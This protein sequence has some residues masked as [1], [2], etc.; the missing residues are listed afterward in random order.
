MRNLIPENKKIMLELP[1]YIGVRLTKGIA[2][3]TGGRRTRNMIRT[4]TV[5]AAALVVSIGLP[6]GLSATPLV[7]EAT[8]NNLF[9]TLN[10]STGTFAELTNFG[11]TPTGLGEIGDA[12]YTGEF[13]GSTLYSVNQTN[14]AP[15][16]IGNLSNVTFYTLGSTTTGLYMVDMQGG[17]WNINP[18]TGANTFIGATGVDMSTSIYAGLSTGSSILYFSLGSNIY[19]INTATGLA[20]F[21]GTSGSTDFGALISVSNTVYGTSVVAPNSIYT[22][23]PTTGLAAFLTNASGDYAFGLA[24]IVSEPSSLGLLGLG[25]AGS[26]LVGYALKRTRFSYRISRVENR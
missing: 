21:I 18:A 19:T 1:R 17:L 10:L 4:L 14:G 8:G 24:A 22:F 3:W 6:A 13:G 15:R 20:S 5:L 26:L 11:F 25:I 9:G 12:L 7:W 16:A 2:F 23:N